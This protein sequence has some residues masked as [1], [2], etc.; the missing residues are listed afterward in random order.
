VPPFV[1]SGW[2]VKGDPRLASL[3]WLE[4]GEQTRRLMNGR[5][6]QVNGVSW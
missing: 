3:G 6:D 2:T 1:M 5:D 4:N